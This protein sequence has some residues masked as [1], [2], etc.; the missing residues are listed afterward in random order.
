M[1]EETEVVIEKMPVGEL[2]GKVSR[3][4]L[5]I[6]VVMLLAGTVL[7]ITVNLGETL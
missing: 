2:L 5:D 6:V 4:F 1:D 7:L 3:P